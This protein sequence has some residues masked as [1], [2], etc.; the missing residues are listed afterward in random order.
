MERINLHQTVFDKVLTK[1]LKKKTYVRCKFVSSIPFEADYES[2]GQLIKVNMIEVF[3]LFF[4][5][6][7]LYIKY[8]I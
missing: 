7:A 2:N 3:G 8:I 6:M 5:T 1:V 4:I